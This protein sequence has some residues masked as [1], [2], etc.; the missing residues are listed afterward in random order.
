MSEASQ[1]VESV[2]P[3][4]TR[5]IDDLDRRALGYLAVGTLVSALS[6]VGG[7][8]YGMWASRPVAISVNQKAENFDKITDITLFRMSMRP[9]EYYQHGPVYC[10]RS[11]DRANVRCDVNAY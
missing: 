5:P 1:A 11:E 3:T 2:Q 7:I 9:A 6:F 10:E 8:E 4:K